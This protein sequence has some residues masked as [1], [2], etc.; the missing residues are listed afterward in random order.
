MGGGGGGGTGTG[1]HNALIATADANCTLTGY[2]QASAGNFTITGAVDPAT[3]KSVDGT[4]D[5][6]FTVGAQTGQFKGS[7]QAPVCP[8]AKEIPLN[9]V[10]CL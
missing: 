5:I 3:V 9:N 2:N 6:T 8:N 4:F 1:T 10:N 7:F